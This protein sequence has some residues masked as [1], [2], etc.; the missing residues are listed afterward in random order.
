V[1]PAVSPALAASG[2]IRSSKQEPPSALLGTRR[3]RT[4]LDRPPLD[5]GA[6]MNFQKQVRIL[7]AKLIREKLFGLIQPRRPENRVMSVA[8]HK[9]HQ[10]VIQ[11]PQAPLLPKCYPVELQQIPYPCRERWIPTSGPRHRAFALR[12]P[13]PYCDYRLPGRTLRPVCARPMGQAPQTHG[14]PLSRIGRPLHAE[15]R[16]R[17]R[18]RRSPSTNRGGIRSEGPQGKA[19]PPPRAYRDWHPAFALHR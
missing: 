6:W 15:A 13:A 9:M 18:P 7:F 14:A 16:L 19:T 10:S 5:N 11:Q 17:S 2:A 8:G 1:R 12:A 4:D 3:S